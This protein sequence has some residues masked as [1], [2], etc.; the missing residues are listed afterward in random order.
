MTTAPRKTRGGCGERGEWTYI[1]GRSQIG[2]IK[3]SEADIRT[4]KRGLDCP[5]DWSSS[6]EE[7]PIEQIYVE[8]QAAAV[9]HT[10]TGYCRRAPPHFA[11]V[12]HY[13]TQLLR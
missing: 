2:L 1:D 10:V 12:L 13:C 5:I 3:T 4:V 7:S 8:P 6:D 9:P 11:A